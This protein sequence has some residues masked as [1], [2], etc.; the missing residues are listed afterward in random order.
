MEEKIYDR[1]V[2]KLATAKRV[3]D[4]Q[5]IDRHFKENDRNDLYSIKNINPKGERKQPILPKDI[6]LAALLK[7]YPD[8]IYKY[9]EH[10]S[11]LENKPDE[12]LSKKEIEAAWKTFNTIN[13]GKNQPIVPGNQRGAS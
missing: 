12:E 11:L 5:Q 10:D 4:D 13:G 8:R 6:M 3:I 1:Q 2:T 7:K 9:H